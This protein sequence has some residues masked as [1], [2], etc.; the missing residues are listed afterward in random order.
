MD[1]SVVFLWRVTLHFMSSS[2]RTVYFPSWVLEGAKSQEIAWGLWV[3]GGQAFSQSENCSEPWDGVWS[4][5]A[6]GLVSPEGTGG[7]HFFR[8]CFSIK[9]RKRRGLGGKSW[10]VLSFWTHITHN[11]FPEKPNTL[12]W[13]ETASCRSAEPAPCQRGDENKMWLEK[14]RLGWAEL[15]CSGAL[16][17]RLWGDCLWCLEQC[18]GT[19]WGHRWT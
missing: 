14:G 13:W 16:R 7:R 15:S 1:N 5:P 12:Q 10:T 9:A 3:Q 19:S 17:P 2:W 18:Q 6:D 8:N 4:L 11:S